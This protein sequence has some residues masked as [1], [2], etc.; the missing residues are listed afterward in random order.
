MSGIL[1]SPVACCASVSEDP[2]SISTSIDLA[3]AFCIASKVSATLDVSP[4]NLDSIPIC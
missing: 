2:E 3:I 1:T 4:T